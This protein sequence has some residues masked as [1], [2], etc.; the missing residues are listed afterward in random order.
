M[1]LSKEEIQK[2]K[3]TIPLVIGRNIRKAR[4]E[5]GL[6]Q[7]ELSNL[8]LS[9]R[10]Y[11]YKIETAKVSVSIVK[12]AILAKALEVSIAQLVFEEV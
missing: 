10:Q 1:E 9:D 4:E 2:L 12:L 8:K 6:T 11:M 5:K 3:E 7:T